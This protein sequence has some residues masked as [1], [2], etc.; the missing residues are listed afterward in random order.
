M[1][2]GLGIAAL[3]VIAYVVQLSWMHRLTTPWYLPLSGTLAVAFVVASLVQARTVW[4][5]AALVLV[6]LIAAAGWLWVLG[7]PLPKY[8]GTAKAGDPFPKFETV[9]Y[10]GTPFTQDDLK[11]D[12]D[13]VMVFFR[14]R[15]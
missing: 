3:G 4:R 2:Q 15:W 5:V 13:T 11:G 14:G 1:L 8:D 7:L 9:R 6:V 10:D 12:K